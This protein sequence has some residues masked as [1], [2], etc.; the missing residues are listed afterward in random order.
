M[1]GDKTP[2]IP[3]LIYEPTKEIVVHGINKLEIKDLVTTRSSS[4]TPNPRLLW[5]EGILFSAAYAAD[6]KFHDEKIDNGTLFI[7]HLYYAKMQK[8]EPILSIDTDQYGGIKAYVDDV[9]WSKVYKVIISW[10][11]SYDIS[12]K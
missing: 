12:L 2:E 6:A 11:K 5:C 3:K 8:Y 1:S 4:S 9:S 7:Q 10:L